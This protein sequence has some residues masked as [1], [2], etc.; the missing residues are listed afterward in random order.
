MKHFIKKRD[1]PAR[2]KEIH[3]KNKTVK[4]PNIFFINTKRFHAPDYADLTIS[5]DEKIEKNDLIISQYFTYPSSLPK[6][7]QISFLNNNINKNEDYS[8]IPGKQD[9]IDEALKNN[10]TNLLIIANSSQLFKNVKKFVDYVV[11]LREKTKEKKIIYLPSVGNPTNLALLAYIGIDLFDSTQAVVAA[12]NNQ[13]FLPYYGLS[14]KNNLKEL[15]CLCP[16]CNRYRGN[17]S[18][19][20]FKNIFEHNCYMFLNEIKNIRN[21]INNGNLRDLV[22]KQVKNS[23]HLT[24]MLRYLDMK[25]YSF[26]EKHTP[27]T[28]KNIILATSKETFNRSEIKRFQQRVIN[29]YRKPASAKVLLLL[30]CSAKKPYSFSESHKLFQ[31][32]INSCG[33]PGVIH[34]VIITSPVG[35]V[36]LELELVYPASSYDIPVTGVWDEDEK[37]MITDLLKRYLKKNKYDKVIAHLPPEII[38]FIKD[39]LKNSIVT[40][41]GKP[42]SKKSLSILSET[43]KNIVEKFEKVDS[44]KRRTENVFSLAC[45]QFGEEIAEKLIRNC[46]VKG[47]YPYEKIFHGKQQIGMIVGER[48][49]ISLTLEGGK[50][51]SEGNSY[52]VEIYDDFQLKGSVFAPG[53]VN[54]DPGIRIGDEIVVTCNKKTIGVGVALMNGEDMKQLNHGE[55]VKIRHHI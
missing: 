35:I 6:N 5:D 53:I 50:R 16:A 41:T 12:R 14:D 26:L 36:P 30:P 49:F 28:G 7:L 11:Y 23:P 54:A 29:R 43:L 34:E 10:D 31:E 38:N 27:V 4:T 13:L 21:H 3:I 39:L 47:R 22:E 24:T 55:A 33:N 48:G 2:L 37:K 9:V 46:V 42:T 40:C 20:S 1:G 19:M 32:K 52:T 25:Y 44:E 15:S 8:I 51:I 45:Y 18:S 17:P